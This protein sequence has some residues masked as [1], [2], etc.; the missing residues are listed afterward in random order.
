MTIQ[1]SELSKLAKLL[2]MLGSAHDGEVVNAAR[3][4]DELI[5]KHDATWSDIIGARD[6]ESVVPPKIPHHDIALEL[7]NAADL[8]TD[9]DQKLTAKQREILDAIQAKVKIAKGG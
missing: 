7:L 8:L 6:T 3:K 5:R 1:P 4:A 2:G 9:F